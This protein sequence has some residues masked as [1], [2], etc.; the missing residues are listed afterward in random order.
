VVEFVSA[1]I[2]GLALGG[3]LT[4]ISLGLVL[5]FRA[6]R[7]F[8]FAHGELM[9]IPA[10]IVGD[11]SARHV[12]IGLAILIALGVSVL[13]GAAIYL[14]VIRR[15]AGLPLFMGVIATFGMAAALDGGIGL[16]FGPATQ[17]LLT[18]PAVPQGSWTLAGATFASS[19]VVIGVF[20]LLLAAVVAGVIR[21]THLGVRIRAAGEN[22][23]LASQS[24][25]KVNRMYTGSWACASLLA[26]VA[27]IAYA[28]T[29]AANFNIVN[30]GLAAIP[31]IVIGGMDS[32]EGALIGGMFIGLLQ[33]F[34]QIYLGG[35]YVN[36]LTYVILLLFLLVRPE[37]LLGTKNVARA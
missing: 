34:T 10:F 32:V 31:A 1:V 15:T 3:T 29:A 18:I 23:V 30:L 25:I 35:R 12:S 20:T 6:T 14:V 8:N 27:G 19:E 22:P 5:A 36:L 16:I 4:L 28:G 26:G 17:Y 9:L 13:L 24:G 21:F 2:A 7:T 33:A 11:L 37:G